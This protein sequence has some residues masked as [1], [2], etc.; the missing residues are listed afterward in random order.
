MSTLFWKTL[1]AVAGGMVVGSAYEWSQPSVPH[2]TTKSNTRLKTTTTY[3]QTDQL[4]YQL[5]LDIDTVLGSVD[6]VAWMRA[7]LGVDALVG[8]K[9]S[10]AQ[11]GPTIEVRIDAFM[12][13]RN[14]S[15]SLQRCLQ[16]I[17]SNTQYDPQQVVRMQAQCI[18]LT[19]CVESYLLYIVMSTRDV[20]IRPSC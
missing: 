4:L 18:R 8:C 6:A 11:K 3:V 12:H 20:Y 16:C 15:E 1:I 13:Y 2:Q 14:F 17:E 9:R 19:E 5:L 7:I 10:L